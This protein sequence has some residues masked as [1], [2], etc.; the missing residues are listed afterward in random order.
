MPQNVGF[1]R[2]EVTAKLGLWTLI[3]DCLEG[4][5]KIKSAKDTYLPRPNASD[6]SDENKKRYDAY[7][8][9]AVFYNVTRRTLDGLVGQ[10]FIREPV[11]EIPDRLDPLVEDIAGGGVGLIEQS[12][13]TLSDV[14]SFGRSGLLVDYPETDGPVTVA[15]QEAG[16]VRPT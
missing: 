15:Q 13:K 2:S 4:Q 14:V 10:V 3:R 7:I 8:Q 9:R 6:T 5:A 1:V 11:S 12:K 16:F